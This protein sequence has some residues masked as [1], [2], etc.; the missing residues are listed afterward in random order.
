[1]LARLILS[2]EGWASAAMMAAILAPTDAAPSL[3]VVTSKAVPG[4]DPYP[5]VP[6]YLLIPFPRGNAA[7]PQADARRLVKIP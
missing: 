4:E 3:Q 7:S 6:L 5:Q 1:M 2:G